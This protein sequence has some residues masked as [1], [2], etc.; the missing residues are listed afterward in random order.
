M[1]PWKD[2]IPMV[3]QASKGSFRPPPTPSPPSGIGLAF[4][5][6]TA[7]VEVGTFISEMSKK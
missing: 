1:D 6:F 5:I 4:T 7:V 3:V 2:T